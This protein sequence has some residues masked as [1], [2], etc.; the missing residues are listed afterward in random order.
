MKHGIAKIAKIMIGGI[1]LLIVLLLLIGLVA[2]REFRGSISRDIARSPEAIYAWLVDFE[3]IPQRRPEIKAV[4][5]GSNN[6]QGLP[7]WTEFHGDSSSIF[8]L[9]LPELGFNSQSLYP[10]EKTLTQG[11]DLF[12]KVL[13]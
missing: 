4:E 9:P 7:V 12:H 5:M 10:W 1:A 6:E 13:I 2:P 8:T 11:S 3:Q